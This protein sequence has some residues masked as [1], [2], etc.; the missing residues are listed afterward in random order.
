MKEEQTIHKNKSRVKG[1]VLAVGSPSGH[2]LKTN[3][4]LF[5][6]QADEGLKD[7]ALPL[8]LFCVPTCIVKTRETLLDQK[9]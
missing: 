1:D 5:L 9:R 7:R 2:K 3:I 6:P 8:T 4:F